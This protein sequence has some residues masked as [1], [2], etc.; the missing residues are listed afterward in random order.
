MTRRLLHPQI[1]AALLVAPTLVWA[2][3]PIAGPQFQ[4][5]SETSSIQQL[6]S[7]AIAPDGDFVV[8][9]HGAG[10]G[11]SYGVYAR[12]FLGPGC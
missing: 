7:V 5:N 2:G 8:A 12:V 1:F 11:D 4:V 9:W 6:P 10:L 3:G